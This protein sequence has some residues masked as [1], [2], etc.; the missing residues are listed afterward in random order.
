MNH[1]QPGAPPSGPGGYPPPPGQPPYPQGWPAPGGPPPK[2]GRTGLTL[3][4][5]AAGLVLVLVV[6]GAVALVVRGGD[7]E[8][9]DSGAGGAHEA[10]CEVYADVVSSSEIWAA[11]E[12]DPD[13]LQEMYDAALA[14]ITDDEIEELVSAEATVVVA[15][16]RAVAEWKQSMMDALGRGESP[17]T[18]LPDE[19]TTQQGEI[20]RVQGAVIEACAD[21]LPQREDD[22]PVP[23]VTAPSLDKPTWMDE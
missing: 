3:A 13:K 15:Y 22:A 2:R 18:T 21:V 4:L 16:Y 23:R 11:T 6:I 10:S 14:D 9:S 5:L 12:F 8:D 1:P 20:P 19:L 17:E 7:A